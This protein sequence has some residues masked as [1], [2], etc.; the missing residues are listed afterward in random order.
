[1]A[2]QNAFGG[3]RARLREYAQMREDGGAAEALAILRDDILMSPH[4]TVF[5]EM[6]HQR[7]N[8][9]DIRAL[10]LRAPEAA[11]WPLTR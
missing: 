11:E 8:L 10:L 4:L 9:P 6:R 2:R 3:F 5:A 7:Q 1:M